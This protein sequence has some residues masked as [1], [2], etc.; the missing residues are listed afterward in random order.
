MFAGLRSLCTI[1]MRCRYCSAHSTCKSSR[2]A[3]G[4]ESAHAHTLR[5]CDGTRT[6]NA[7][8]AR[9]RRVHAYADQPKRRN[10]RNGAMR[11]ACAGSRACSA[12]WASVGSGS[13]SMESRRLVAY[14]FQPD[15]TKHTYTNILIWRCD[16]PE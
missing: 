10:G 5:R 9:P 12:I 6:P 7:R 15:S 8:P 1:P 16:K 3:H 14:G 13:P 2:P 4:G 11:R